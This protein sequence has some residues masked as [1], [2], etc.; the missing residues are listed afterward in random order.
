MAL[1]PC[2]RRIRRTEFNQQVNAMTK[3]CIVN[4][5]D[6]GASHGINRGILEAHQE[7]ILTS[8]SLMVDMPGAAEAA[9]LS[10]DCPRLSIGLHVVLTNEGGMPRLDFDSSKSCRGEI[11]RQWHRFV[12]LTGRPPTHLDAHHNIYRDPRLTPLF[13]E[14]AALKIIP[15][16]EHSNVHYFPEFYGQW[17]GEPHLEQIGVDSLCDMLR[18]KINARFTELGCHPGYIDGVFESSYSIER[19]AELRTL[20]SPLVR[21]TVDSLGIRLISYKDLAG[22]MSPADKESTA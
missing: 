3:Y 12:E 20:C 4:G 19:E 9:R 14:W 5:D 16:R 22:I 17:D 15:L 6:F 2:F 10:S 7:G 13:T 1:S 21:E 8:T 11:A 18:T